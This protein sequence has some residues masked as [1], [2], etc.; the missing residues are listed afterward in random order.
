IRSAGWSRKYS[1]NSKS[2]LVLRASRASLEKMRPVMWPRLTSASIRRA[3]GCSLTDL[4]ETPARSYTS[5]TV[6]PRAAAYDLARSRWWAGLSP[7]AWS[8]LETRI[9]MP[10]DLFKT[11]FSFIYYFIPE[12]AAAWQDKNVGNPPL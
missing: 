11:L 10:T 7:L 5:L 2:S 3:S 8:S 12:N 4:P 9:Q 1:E 6:Q